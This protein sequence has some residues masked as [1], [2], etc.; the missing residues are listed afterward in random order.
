MGTRQKENELGYQANEE[1]SKTVPLP[2]PMPQELRYEFQAAMKKAVRQYHFHSPM[3]QELR[4]KHQGSDQFSVININHV[5][6]QFR[7][8]IKD[9]DGGYSDAWRREGA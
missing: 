3:P 1:G 8:T 4:H 2:Q 5:A 7:V 9:L 6:H